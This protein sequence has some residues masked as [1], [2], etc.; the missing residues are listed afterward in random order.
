ML[1]QKHD[2]IG[3]VTNDGSWALLDDYQYIKLN[4]EVN[5]TNLEDSDTDNITDYTELGNHETQN[6]NYMIC[7][8][9]ATN[10]VPYEYYSGKTTVEVD[11]KRQ[12]AV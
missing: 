9:L 10:G 6:L 12:R 3:E 11:M 2:K 1:L 7:Y 5:S 8:L 4:A